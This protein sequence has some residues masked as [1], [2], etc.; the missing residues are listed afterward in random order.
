[1]ATNLTK[2]DIYNIAK[3]KCENWVFEY[4]QG[5]KYPTDARILDGNGNR[6][7]DHLVPIEMANEIVTAHNESLYAALFKND[8][9]LV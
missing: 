8:C 9:E 4:H 3:W 1:M 5:V 6:V 7:F 2:K